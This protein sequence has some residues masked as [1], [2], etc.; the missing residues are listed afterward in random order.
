MIAEG[1]T[2]LKGGWIIWSKTQSLL[3][4]YAIDTR[5]SHGLAWGR[6]GMYSGTTDPSKPLPMKYHF[7]SG[8]HARRKAFL[9]LVIFVSLSCFLLYYVVTSL[10]THALTVKAH[11]QRV[12]SLE[13]QILALE[14]EI[15]LGK[16]D[17]Y[18]QNT[19]I[20]DALKSGVPDEV[21]RQL[22]QVQRSLHSLAV[23]RFKHRPETSHLD[24][25]RLFHKD[26]RYMAEVGRSRIVLVESTVLN[27]DCESIRLRVLRS[28]QPLTG[29]GIAFARIV[30]TVGVTF[31]LCGRDD[32]TRL[33]YPSTKSML[34]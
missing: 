25:R 10:N 11:R 28:P 17:L 15:V 22:E 34:C 33:C 24:C 27:M 5:A 32:E 13:K 12:A 9:V 30:H 2:N 29:Y 23:P 6:T 18:K 7:L 8:R 16:R 26:K 4:T 19:A 21:R 31:D 3:A 14:K 1:P 20:S